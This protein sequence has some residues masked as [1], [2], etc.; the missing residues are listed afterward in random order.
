MKISNLLNRFY[1]FF[2][3]KKVDLTTFRAVIIPKKGRNHL[4]H[5]YYFSDFSLSF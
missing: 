4:K 3:Q 5:R 2:S 1:Q